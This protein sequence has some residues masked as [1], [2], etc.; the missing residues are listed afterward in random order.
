MSL[1]TFSFALV[2]RG[3]HFWSEV[4]VGWISM[5]FRPA[6]FHMPSEWIVIGISL[7]AECHYR[8]SFLDLSTAFI[9]D[10]TW[11]AF[12]V[13]LVNVLVWQTEIGKLEI[14]CTT[15]LLRIQLCQICGITSFIK[16]T[17]FVI[18]IYHC[19]HLS[20]IAKI[21]IPFYAFNI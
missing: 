1:V 16:N 12:Q 20:R 13:T 8:L 18:C 10:Q 15:F 11:T 2:P 3:W 9:F 6:D 19:F 5:T 21:L 7:A 4:T 17:I 14:C